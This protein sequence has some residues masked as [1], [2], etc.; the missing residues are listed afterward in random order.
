M[1]HLTLVFLMLVLIV[2]TIW[3]QESMSIKLPA[4]NIPTDQSFSDA[5]W[6]RHSSREFSEMQLS[7]QELSNVLWSANGINRPE[8]GHR[9]APSARNKQDIDIYAVLKDGIYLYDA[10]KHELL[11]IANGDY[12]QF[13]G[14]QDYVAKAPVNLIY[15]SDIA[16][17]DYTD[18]EEARL[19]TGGIDAGHC[20]Q[21]VY[22]YCAIAKLNVVVRA[23]VGKEKLTEL[24]KLRPEQKV[25]IGQTIG[26]PQAK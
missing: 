3:A 9:T 4:V 7:L 20:S 10:L 2:S 5:I 26:Y 14:T 16:K 11:P 1:K 18:D 8:T 19:L 21:N 24:L 6:N 25:I 12:R 15:V 23:S 17:F 13:A 22:L